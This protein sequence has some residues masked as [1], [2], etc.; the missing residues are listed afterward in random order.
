ML[1]ATARRRAKV[2]GRVSIRSGLSRMLGGSVNAT[3]APREFSML[4]VRAMYFSAGH[5]AT[6]TSTWQPE[7]GSAPR[8][9]MPT[10][11]LIGLEGSRRQGD[12]TPGRM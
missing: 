12:Q 6:W 9:V 4:I 5:E 2:S 8:T 1:S 10:S 11:P 7:I 3:S